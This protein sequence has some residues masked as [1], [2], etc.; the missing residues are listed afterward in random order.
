MFQRFKRTLFGAGL[1]LMLGATTQ[2]GSSTT[3]ACASGCAPEGTGP[4]AGPQL[5]CT[6]SVPMAH[7][8]MGA[9]CPTTRPPGFNNPMGTLGSFA[10][11]CTVDSQC[12]TGTNPRCTPGKAGSPR[13]CTSDAC[14]TDADCGSGALCECG[15]DALEEPY[16]GG[17]FPNTCLPSNCQ[18]DADC[19]AGGYCSPSFDA[20]CGPFDGVVGYYCHRAADQC[21]KDECTNDADCRGVG[22]GYCEWRPDAAKWACSYAVCAG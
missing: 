2:C 17:R 8:L 21:T 5:G 10:Q 4:A 19:G 6:P 18:T 14:S 13:L 11:A 16:G 22:P 1:L 9:S 12:T 3:T 20:M 7:R 15:I